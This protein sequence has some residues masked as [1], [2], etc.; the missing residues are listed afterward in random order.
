M[1]GVRMLR[2]GL[3]FSS[4]T[5][6]ISIKINGLRVFCAV[7]DTRNGRIRKTNEIANVCAR[8]HSFIFVMSDGA[9]IDNVLNVLFSY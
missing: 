2:V 9:R 1:K 8:D 4:V 6:L 3:E 7:G 5:S